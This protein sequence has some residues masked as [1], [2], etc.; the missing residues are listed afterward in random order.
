MRILL[1]N[2][3]GY[4][5]EGIKELKRV[6]SRAYD[7]LLIAPEK[8]MSASSSS[9]TLG[10]PLLPKKIS[11]SSYA[12]DGTPSDCVHMAL[13]GF[14]KEKI[15]LVV[16]GINFGPNLGDDVIYSGTVAGAI[17]GRFIGLPSIAFSLASWKGK[18]F[19][20]AARIALKI[21]ENLQHLNVPTNTILNI[22]IPDLPLDEIR[23]I[24]ATR[25]GSRHKSDEI[26]QDKNN[27]LEYW[28]GKNGMELDNKK[29]TDFHA[30]AND[31]VSVTPLQID[32]TSKS[33]LPNLTDWV[34]KIK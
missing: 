19:K 1:S 8:N 16:T 5:S 13:C 28:I 4:D 7:I 22:N 21:I 25:L 2:D 34:S 23:G 29:G 14:F 3:D 20:S 31:Y 15:D 27:P 33:I 12:V 10:K 18:N 24:K 26:I 17:E 30:I 11:S 9:L 6:L 32:L